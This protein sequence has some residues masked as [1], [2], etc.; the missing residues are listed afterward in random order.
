MQYYQDRFVQREVGDLDVVC[1][2]YT[3]G[4]SWEGKLHQFDQHAT[5]DLVKNAHFSHHLLNMISTYF[6][7]SRLPLHFLLKTQ[8]QR[9]NSVIFAVNQ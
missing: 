3:Y 2:L 4:C 9:E 8:P 1:P 5:Q 7:S 6:P